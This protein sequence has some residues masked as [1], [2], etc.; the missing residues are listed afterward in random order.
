V[1]FLSSIFLSSF[2]FVLFVFL[3]ANFFRTFEETAQTKKI[4]TEKLGTEKCSCRT[5]SERMSRTAADRFNERNAEIAEKWAGD[6]AKP[7]TFFS[8]LQSLEFL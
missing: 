5:G 7:R 6:V 4:G 3:V 2:S 8:A 1:I